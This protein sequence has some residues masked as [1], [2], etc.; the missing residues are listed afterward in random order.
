MG[1][2]VLL[3]LSG[4]ALKGADGIFDAKFING[5]AEKIKEFLGAGN[6]LGIVVGAGNIFRGRYAEEIGIEA[7]KGDEMGMLGTVINGYAI[8]AALKAVGVEAVI[9]SAIGVESFVE[10]YTADAAIDYMRDGRVVIFVGGT[11]LPFFTTDTAAVLRAVETKCSMMLKA[12]QVDGIYSSDPSRDSG[13]MKYDS[14]SYADV[15]SNRLGVL[16]ATA[17]ALA[18]DKGI[19]IAIFSIHN[20]LSIRSAIDNGSII[21]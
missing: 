18:M 17:I 21:E 19:R 16:D 12:T 10:V 15:L 2:R 5:L 6:E 9:L 7:I 8:C 14:I 4:E 1:E 3:K 11:G 20:D 13:A